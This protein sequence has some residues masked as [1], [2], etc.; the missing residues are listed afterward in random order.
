MTR[1]Q[2]F[3]E[4]HFVKAVKFPVTLLENTKLVFIKEIFATVYF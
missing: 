1:H 4:Q 3:D 2:F